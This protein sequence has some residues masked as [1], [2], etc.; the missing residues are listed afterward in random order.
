MSHIRYLYVDRLKPDHPLHRAVHAL[1]L[2]LKHVQREDELFT[3]PLP[4]LVL[5]EFKRI[6]PGSQ[7][8]F[9]IFAIEQ[10]A[11]GDLAVDIHSKGRFHKFHK[12][13]LLDLIY[14]AYFS[15]GMPS[16]LD[17]LSEL[18]E[19]ISGIRKR[20]GGSSTVNTRI[21]KRMNAVQI[22][23]VDAYIQHLFRGWQRELPMLLDVTTTNTTSFFREADQI[24]HVVQHALSIRERSARTIYIWSAACSTGQ[25]PY[26][27]AAAIATAFHERGFGLGRDIGVRIIATDISKRV[28]SIA[29]KGIYPDQRLGAI[30][31]QVFSRLF[32]RGEGELKGWLRVKDSIH[33]MVEF[34]EYNLTQLAPMKHSFDAIFCRNV[35]IYFEANTVQRIVSMFS[36]ALNPEGNLYIGSTEQIRP[37]GSLKKTFQS[38]FQKVRVQTQT[39]T[40]TQT[41]QD[42][43]TI[44]KGE[45]VENHGKPELIVVGAS[46]GGT[47]AIAV[48]VERIKGA[49]P[50]LIIAQ[51]LP[52]H[53]FDKFQTSLAA[54]T[55][56]KVKFVEDREVLTENHIYIAPGGKQTRV[57]KRGPQLVAEVYTDDTRD[58]Q[59]RPNIDVLFHSAAQVA[60]DFKVVGVLLSGMGRDGADG[61]ADMHRAGAR[62]IVQDKASSDVYGMP[63]A[64]IDL[65]AVDEVVQLI[66]IADSMLGLML[67]LASAN[68][69]VHKQVG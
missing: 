9:P 14:K 63:Q 26:S 50:P 18:L 48:I 23:T 25:E 69:Q 46:T 60:E 42:R 1:G 32:D 31:A 61:M 51:H 4:L 41:K 47:K 19:R 68:S 24:Q 34:K 67:G 64:A 58:Q 27:I 62:C 35:F 65:G 28:L 5:M 40:Q 49:I 53:F 45:R 39:H 38:T 16:N 57:R 33:R 56:L 21:Q 29:R 36:D 20:S 2:T 12:D 15:S 55:D 59:F 13:L 22:K 11:S 37:L 52:E 43:E 17:A 10:R 44:A 30:P 54:R 8:P 7:T 6:R 3:Q 66:R